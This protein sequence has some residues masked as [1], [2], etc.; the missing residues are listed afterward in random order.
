MFNSSNKNLGSVERRGTHTPVP[1]NLR[2]FLNPEQRRALR[3]IE[4]FGW[5]L[6]FVRR[7]VF[8]ESVVVVV[9]SEGSVF[10][11]IEQDGF[12]NAEPSVGLRL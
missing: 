7:E 8:H 6:A 9:N 5:R 12:I 4:N 11:T 3:Q 2:E 10:S 1:L